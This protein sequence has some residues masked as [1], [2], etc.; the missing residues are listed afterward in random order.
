MN[1]GWFPLLL[2]NLHWSIEPARALDVK[3]FIS[4]T[5]RGPKVL[6]VLERTEDRKGSGSSLQVGAGLWCLS[7]RNSTSG[8]D[9][10]IV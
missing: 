3:G 10:P 5:P 7:T 6:S 4:K 8:S 1:L 9:S 2:L